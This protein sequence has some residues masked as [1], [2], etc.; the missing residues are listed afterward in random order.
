MSTE[1]DEPCEVSTCDTEDLVCPYCLY[2][3]DFSD[4]ITE[5]APD[6]V[7][8]CTGCGR[9]FDYHTLVTRRYWTQRHTK[10]PSPPAAGEVCDDPTVERVREQL[11]QR[12]KLGVSKYGQTV[13]DNPLTREAW[14]QHALEEHLDG[15]VYLQRLIDLERKATDVKHATGKP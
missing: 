15:A 2:E 7:L 6:G 5:N 12:S 3:H 10:S 14:L 9:L 8:D 1:A 13:A 11:L 4:E